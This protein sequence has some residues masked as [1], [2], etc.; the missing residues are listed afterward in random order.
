MEKKTKFAFF[1]AGNLG[2]A[3]AGHLALQGYDVSLCNRNTNKLQAIIANDNYINL[4]GVISGKGKLSLVTDNYEEAIIGRDIIVIATSAPGH[5]A[6]VNRLIPVLKPTQHIV[7]H[8]SYMMGAVEIHQLL[9]KHNLG[10]IPV[11][12][13]TNALFACRANFVNVKILAIKE[14]LG[15]ATLPAHR[16][17][18]CLEPFKP[19]YGNYL[20]SYDNVMETSMLNLNFGSLA[21]VS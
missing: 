9:I 8:P 21:K 16:T 14:S 6:I 13:M 7:L 1:G 10:N 5:K 4:S 20:E 18:E 15:F 19:L 3:H 2:L 17:E 11:S 12:E